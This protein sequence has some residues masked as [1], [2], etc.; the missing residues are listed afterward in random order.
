MHSFPH[1]V[2]SCIGNFSNEQHMFGRVNQKG[3]DY[4]LRQLFLIA[5][6]DGDVAKL[7]C[8]KLAEEVGE[9]K[10]VEKKYGST[11]SK[12]DKEHFLF[13][14]CKAF[15]SAWNHWCSDVE[16]LQRRVRNTAAEAQH[17]VPYF[18]LILP[19]R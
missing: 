4:F 6:R 17:L 14:N 18:D 1:L 13:T 12:K 2:P 5:Y 9:A 10:A 8:S 19:S 16:D 11:I 3:L 15:E 7:S